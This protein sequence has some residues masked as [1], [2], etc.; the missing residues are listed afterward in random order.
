MPGEQQKS[1]RNA[2]RYR[3]I[4]VFMTNL[5]GCLREKRTLPLMGVY[6]NNV[7]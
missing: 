7:I 2:E 6:K 5:H 4:A 3:G 1:R